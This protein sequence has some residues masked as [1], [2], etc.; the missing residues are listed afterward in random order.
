M[1]VTMETLYSTTRRKPHIIRIYKSLFVIT[2]CKKFLI[3]NQKYKMFVTV[4]LLSVFH[5]R[6][7][8]IEIIFRHYVRSININNQKYLK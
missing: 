7:T 8:S 2:I 6:E 3:E 5:K 1:Q 4:I